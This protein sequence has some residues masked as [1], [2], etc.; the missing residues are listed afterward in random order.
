MQEVTRAHKG[1]ALDTVVLINDVTKMTKEEVTESPA[2]GVYVHGLLLDGA[3]WDKEESKLIE[4]TAKVSVMDLRITY[5][6]P[7]VAIYSVLQF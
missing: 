3:A 1:W 4:S 6:C 7:S 2:E 5:Y